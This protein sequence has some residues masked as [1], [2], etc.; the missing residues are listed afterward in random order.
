MRELGNKYFRHF[1][2]FFGKD[3][4]TEI[5]QQYLVTEQIISMSGNVFTSRLRNCYGE[6]TAG[7]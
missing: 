6:D 4:Q 3:Y 2:A 1:L 7:I 5:V